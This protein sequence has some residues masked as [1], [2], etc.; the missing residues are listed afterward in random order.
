MSRKTAALLAVSATAVAGELRVCFSGHGGVFA[1]AASA[2]TLRPADVVVVE[3]ATG[4]ATSG[5]GAGL[6]PAAA[7]SRRSGGNVCSLRMQR[8]LGVTRKDAMHLMGLTFAG[9][10]SALRNNVFLPGREP[11]P[12]RDAFL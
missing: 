3:L 10:V 11:C 2:S 6:R 4:Y 9:A 7:E 12:C 1:R 5:A 8:G